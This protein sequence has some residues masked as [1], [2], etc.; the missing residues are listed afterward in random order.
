LFKDRMAE[1]VDAA[2]LKS[3]ADQGVPVRSR[4]LSPE[5]LEYLAAAKRGFTQPFRDICSLVKTGKM[6]L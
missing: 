6:K 1:Q 2:D 5:L 3:A 4:L